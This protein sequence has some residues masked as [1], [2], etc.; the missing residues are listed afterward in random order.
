MSGMTRQTLTTKKWV[1]AGVRAFVQAGLIDKP[2]HCPV[3]GEIIRRPDQLTM[4]HPR[5]IATL[6][7]ALSVSWICRTCARL[8]AQEAREN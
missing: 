2:N 3:C 1:Q 4:T 5:G 8:E 7:D 6:N